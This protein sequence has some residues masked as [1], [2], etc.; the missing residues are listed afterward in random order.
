MALGS[1]QFKEQGYHLVTLYKTQAV[2][3][4]GLRKNTKLRD[5]LLSL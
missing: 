3:L 5:C 2:Q 4:E 1:M